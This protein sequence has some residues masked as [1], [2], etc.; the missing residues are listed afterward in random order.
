MTVRKILNKFAKL[1][2]IS[3]KIPCRFRKIFGKLW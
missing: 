2:E 1:I 3:E